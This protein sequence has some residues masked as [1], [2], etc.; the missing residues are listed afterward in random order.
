MRLSILQLGM[1]LQV[2]QEEEEI[3]PLAQAECG[4][5]EGGRQDMSGLALILSDRKSKQ[6]LKHDR[7][8]FSFIWFP[9]ER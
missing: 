6:W 9:G 3:P 8:V 1:P 5:E 2:R 7:N 4:K